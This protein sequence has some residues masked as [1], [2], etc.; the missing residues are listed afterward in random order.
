MLEDRVEPRVAVGVVESPLGRR[1]HRSRH[2]VGVET[3]RVEDRRVRSDVRQVELLL[4]ALVA[5]DL[6]RR[7]SESA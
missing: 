6:L 4:E 3:Q 7:R 2:A 1:A 5:N